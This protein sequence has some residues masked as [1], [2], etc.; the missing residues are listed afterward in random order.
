MSLSVQVGGRVAGYVAGVGVKMMV[1]DKMKRKVVMM[2]VGVGKG[3]KGLRQGGGRGGV[4]P[5]VTQTPA[6]TSIIGYIF[7]LRREHHHLHDP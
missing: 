4:A 6:L 2:V 5:G 1:G 3:G 7:H